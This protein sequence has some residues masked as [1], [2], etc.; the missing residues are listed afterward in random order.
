MY[1]W[2]EESPRY[3]LVNVDLFDALESDLMLYD[4][5]G[6]VYTLLEILTVE[7]VNVLIIFLLMMLIHVLMQM[8][9]SLT[10]PFPGPHATRCVMLLV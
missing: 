7:L 3:N 4:D 6:S 8:I 5:I 10:K 9:M 1:R 2:C